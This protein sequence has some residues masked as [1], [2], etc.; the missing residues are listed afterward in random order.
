MEALGIRLRRHA[1]Q[2]GLSDA[3]VARRAGLSERRYGHYV[4]GTREPNLATL[5]KICRVLDTTPN[6][7]FGF[8]K[9]PPIKG[10]QGQLAARLSAAGNALD[11]KALRLAVKQI[12][13][14][15][16]FCSQRQ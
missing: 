2:L 5:L 6:E 8:E 10:E 14:L 4:T 11:T 12:E 16:D 1:R 3:E 15:A 9:V 7:L 13:A